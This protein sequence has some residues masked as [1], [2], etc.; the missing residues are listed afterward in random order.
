M[1]TFPNRKNGNER[2]ETSLPTEN[3]ASQLIYKAYQ[4]HSKG[5]LRKAAEYYQTFLDKGFSDPTVLSNYAV[6]CKTLGQAEKALALYHKCI[7]LF[8][9]HPD[10]LS[11]L[12]NLL[13][14]KGKL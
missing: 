11:N 10:A 3:L 4:F 13:R 9:H 14:D 5:D 1:N 6:I 7:A 8:P 12:A 2:K